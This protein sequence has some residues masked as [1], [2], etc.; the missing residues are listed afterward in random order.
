MDGPSDDTNATLSLCLGAVADGERSAL[1]KLYALTSSRLMGVIQRM[2]RRR[3]IAED[4]LQDTY[5]TI[6]KKAHQFD[7]ER[8]DPMAWLYAIARRKAI[9]HLRRTMRETVGLERLVVEASLLTVSGPA[10]IAPEENITM[11]R[12]MGNLRPDINKALELC[13]AQGLTHEEMAAHL[14]VPLGTAKFWVRRGLAQLK[15]HMTA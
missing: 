2:I 14:D 15:E 6:W 10:P 1:R 8:G 5:V 9:D 3:E 7:P 4:I 13:Y 11:R 12:C